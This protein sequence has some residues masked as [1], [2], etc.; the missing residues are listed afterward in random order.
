MTGVYRMGEHPPWPA[1]EGPV[2][3]VRVRGKTPKVM[4]VVLDSRPSWPGQ[5]FLEV[6]RDDG[7]TERIS[8]IVRWEEKPG[9]RV[10]VRGREPRTGVL[11]RKAL[12]DALEVHVRQ[13]AEIERCTPYEAED[14]R[15]GR[16]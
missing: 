7:S 11:Y 8:R 2:R 6:R 9:S 10:V 1:G 16:A 13:Q 3:G 4:P 14:L 5:F 15:E 12:L